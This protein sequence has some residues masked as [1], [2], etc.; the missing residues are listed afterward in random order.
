MQ[1]KDLWHITRENGTEYSKY[2]FVSGHT[3]IIEKNAKTISF[4]G[5][6]GYKTNKYDTVINGSNA[7]S[8]HC[9][10]Q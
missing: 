9:E 10:Q 3:A 5:P 8:A 4:F 7:I 2:F 6:K 1:V